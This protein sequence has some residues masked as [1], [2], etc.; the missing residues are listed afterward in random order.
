M[1]PK[2]SLPPSLKH[3]DGALAVDSGNVSQR[4][5]KARITCESRTGNPDSASAGFYGVLGEVAIVE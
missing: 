3:Q 1:V 4:K 2:H 5:I